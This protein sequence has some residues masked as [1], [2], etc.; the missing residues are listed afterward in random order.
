MEVIEKSGFII[1]K[2]VKIFKYKKNNDKYWD[3]VKL[4]QQIVT[5]ALL[6]AEILEKDFVERQKFDFRVKINIKTW[7][8]CI[9]LLD[10][11]FIKNLTIFY[12]FFVFLVWLFCKKWNNIFIALLI[13]FWW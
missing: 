4:Y 7:K 2:T 6:I 12:F 10:L 3:K 9:Y 11:Q 8:A 5:K 1:T 13:L